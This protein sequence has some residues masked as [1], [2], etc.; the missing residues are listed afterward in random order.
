MKRVI[1]M[2]LTLASALSI[3][4]CSSAITTKDL[5][6]IEEAENQKV[7]QST[8]ITANDS[9]DNMLPTIAPVLTQEATTTITG[10]SGLSDLTFEIEGNQEVISVRDYISSLG[11]QIKMDEERFTYEA[12][13]G[14]DVY[15]ALNPDA[16]VYPDTYIKITRTDK[17]NQTN[18]LEDLKQQLLSEN[19]RMEELPG[20][21]LGSY[22][23]LVFKSN[24]GSEYNSAI[25]KD[26]VIES[27][28][29]YY[30]IETQYFIEA[31]EGYGAR[32]KALLDTFVINE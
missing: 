25:K 26:Y 5:T 21:K 31:E 27:D 2:A 3:G 15:T 32:M 8:S 24:F 1:Y 14:S 30:T 13:E 23:A 6:I 7:S 4:G 22:D 16:S 19:P 29:S 20:T 10:G 12:T 17:A 11:Y 28:K 9:N 18:Y